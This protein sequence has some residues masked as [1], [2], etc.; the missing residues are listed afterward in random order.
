MWIAVSLCNIIM[1]SSIGYAVYSGFDESRLFYSMF[2]V[3]IFLI[4]CGYTP[5]DPFTNNLCK[6]ALNRARFYL[7]ASILSLIWV[8]YG[9]IFY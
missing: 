4:C 2:G 7:Y 5:F 3:S 9:K 1:A 6:M 8:M